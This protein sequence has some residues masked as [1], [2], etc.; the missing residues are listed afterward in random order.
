MLCEH[1]LLT[2]GEIAEAGQVYVGW[3]ARLVQRSHQDDFKVD[4]DR[5]P[6]EGASLMCPMCRGFPIAC[7]VTMCGHIFCGP[8]VSRLIYIYAMQLICVLMQMHNRCSFPQ[9]EMSGVLDLRISQ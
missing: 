1:T 6:N 7:T 8:C 4:A 2:S 9:E 5:K 3:P